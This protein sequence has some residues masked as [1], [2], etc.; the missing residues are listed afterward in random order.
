MIKEKWLTSSLFRCHECN[1]EWQK[2]ET[3][4]KL[5]EEHCRKTGHT[6]TGEVSYHVGFKK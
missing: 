3:S 4:K 5:A 1:K 2:I 6:V